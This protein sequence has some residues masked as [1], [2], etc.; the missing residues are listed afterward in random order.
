MGRNKIAVGA[1]FGRLTV[2]ER[3]RSDAYHYPHWVCKCDCGAV[4]TVRAG[5]LTSG[6]TSSCGCLRRELLTGAAAKGSHSSPS[7][8]APRLYRIWA[9]MKQRCYNPKRAKFE[10]YGG[11]GIIVCE[12]WKDCFDQFYKWAIS[13]GYRDDLSIDR[14]DVNGNYEPSNCRWATRHEQHINQRPRKK[15]GVE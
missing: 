1:K 2:I 13:N 11:R 12:E 5:N 9:A 3:A 8:C 6:H 14:I 4:T 15:G 7:R 10:H